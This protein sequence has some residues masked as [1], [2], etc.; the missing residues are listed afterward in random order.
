MI[1]SSNLR[2]R[3]KKSRLKTNT[4]S[5][6]RF[7]F[8][9]C[10]ARAEDTK[11]NVYVHFRDGALGRLD[12]AMGRNDLGSRPE[13]R[14][15]A[16]AFCRPDAAHGE[17]DWATLKACSFCI[18]QT[19]PV[20]Q[21]RRHSNRYECALE[22]GD[23]KTLGFIGWRGMVGSV[24][25]ARMREENDFALFEPLFFS[26]SDAGGAAPAFAAHSEPR[27]FDAY[28]ISGAAGGGLERLLD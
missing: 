14:P 11:H 9:H 10:A 7:L 3:W 6:C 12:C 4:V 28:D 16:P 21:A 2:W 27:L 22:N 25:M 24:L 26:T 15:A 13:N 19:V 8:G 17:A 18:F 23:M 5:E 20:Y 1:R